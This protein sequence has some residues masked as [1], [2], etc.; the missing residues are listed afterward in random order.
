MQNSISDVRDSPDVALESLLLL[1]VECDLFS[2]AFGEGH[3]KGVVSHDFLSMNSSVRVS[4]WPVELKPVADAP[5]GAYFHLK[6]SRKVEDIQKIAF[7]ASLVQNA[8][9]FA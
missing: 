8:E 4:D 6:N 2:G 1:E 9:L 3:N 7:V 5:N